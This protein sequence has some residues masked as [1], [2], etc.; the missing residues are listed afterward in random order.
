MALKIPPLTDK[1]GYVAYRLMTFTINL[2]L[3]AYHYLLRVVGLPEIR[4]RGKRD[5]SNSELEVG[6]G[7]EFK[8]DSSVE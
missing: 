7:C 8:V 2:E 3:L 6:V 1:V 5:G 4:I